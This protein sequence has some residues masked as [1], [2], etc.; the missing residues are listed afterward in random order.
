MN[1]SIVPSFI[2]V[3]NIAVDPGVRL[4]TVTIIV[5]GME[6]LRMVVMGSVS[7]LSWT[8][9]SIR[10]RIVVVLIVVVIGV[11][12]TIRSI[13]RSLT[14]VIIVS[15]RTAIGSVRA[16][17]LFSSISRRVRTRPMSRACPTRRTMV[18]E[19]PLSRHEFWKWEVSVTPSF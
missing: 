2:R 8:I 3:I 6:A 15:V 17:S 9:I 5:I 12:S 11:V 13:I 1:R 16:M 4:I 14:Y 19:V 18:G 7:G 10:L